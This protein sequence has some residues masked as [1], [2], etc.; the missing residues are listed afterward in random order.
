MLWL[1]TFV[2]HSS[3]ISQRMERYHIQP[4][5]PVILTPEDQALVAFAIAEEARKDL[6]TLGGYNVLPDHVHLIVEAESETVLAD[7][8]RR[9]KGYTSHVFRQAHDLRGGCHV[10]A[11]KFNRRQIPD[12]E[13]LHRTVQYVMD[14]HLKHLA[15]WGDGLI[16]TWDEKIR[17]VV[18]SACTPLV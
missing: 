4:G 9:I 18:E 13:A 16:S 17:P 5:D 6:I 7:H 1:V 10:W 14:N 8:V 11:Q 2:T 12:D 3:R 15:A